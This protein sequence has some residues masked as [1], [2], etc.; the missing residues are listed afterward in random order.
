M[1][2]LTAKQKKNLRKKLQR[3]RRKGNKNDVLSKEGDDEDCEDQQNEGKQELNIKEEKK[4]GGV[5]GDISNEVNNVAQ[6]TEQLNSARQQPKR[7][8]KKGSA[9]VNGVP[10]KALFSGLLLD[11]D[12]AQQQEE[13]MQKKE[14][15]SKRRGPKLDENVQVK[16]CDMG[17][18]CW[19]YHH[20]TPE[21]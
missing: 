17:N 6:P 2:G 4:Q 8:A 20:F 13:A 10:E 21:I 19:T 3:Q 16:I 9:D 14:E 1:V 18:G 12:L 5:M 7:H 15:K 11:E